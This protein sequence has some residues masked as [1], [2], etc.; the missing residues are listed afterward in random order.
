MERGTRAATRKHALH[1]LLLALGVCAALGPWSIRN[2]FVFGRFMPLA[3]QYPNL[4]GEFVEVG[5]RAWLRTWV[6]DFRYVDPFEWGLN[7]RPIA[8]DAIPERAFDSAAEKQH[9]AMLLSRYAHHDPATGALHVEMTPQLDMAFADLARERL[10]RHPLHCTIGVGARRAFALWFDTHSDFYPFAG[11][12]LPWAKAPNSER[13]LRAAFMLLVWLYTAFSAAAVTRLW[14]S[15]EARD[16]ALPLL[17]FVVLRIV[18]LST[19]ENPEPRYTMEFFPLL[20]S[21]IALGCA[22]TSPQCHAS[23]AQA[24]AIDR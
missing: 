22:R 14:R 10:A 20:A 5:Y 13:V 2:A 11:P 24:S 18:L 3:P 21:L 6:D 16:W 12:L 19:M 15:A 17:A 4:R 1:A 8:L 23:G 9:V 7:S